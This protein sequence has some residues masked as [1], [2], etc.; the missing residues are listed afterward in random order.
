M[1]MKGKIGLKE[2]KP[3]PLPARSTWGPGRLE[4]WHDLAVSDGGEMIGP[5]PLA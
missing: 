3:P 4:H 5:T 1:T 2:K